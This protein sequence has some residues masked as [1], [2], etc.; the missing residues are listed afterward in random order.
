MILI[1][2]AGG[3]LGQCFKQLAEEEGS[4]NALFCDSS[5]LDI[6]DRAAVN[7]FFKDYPIH[8]CINCAAYTMV[9]KAESEVETAH[10]VNVIGVKNLA[11]ACAK[12]GAG[13]IHFS[14]DYVYQTKQNRPFEETDRTQ[15]QGVYAK[16]KLAGERA[17]WRANPLGT[18]I[19]RTSWVYAP[20]GHNFVNTM[21][22]LGLERREV[23]VVF[24]QVGTPTYAPDLAAAIWGILKRATIDTEIR[25]KMVGVWHYSNEGVT[26]WYDF[27]VAVMEL[28]GR[29]CSVLPIESRQYPTPATRPFYSV[30]NKR[31]IK[32]AFHLTI[33]HWR[34]SLQK[35][36]EIREKN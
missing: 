34:D 36:I 12:V 26:S 21:L 11:Q 32:E 3:Q 9:D 1:T 10:R 27:A 22:R 15:P 2:G 24:D 5:T 7:R 23:G 28:G 20:H 14:S 25:R 19:V 13:F 33:P 16:T 31:K 29:N 17:A 30:L 8:W 6:S 35:C 18:M 4:I